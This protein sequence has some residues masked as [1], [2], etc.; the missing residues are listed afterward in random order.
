MTH[1]TRFINKTK[2]KIKKTINKIHKAMR[3]VKNLP[4]IKV[5]NR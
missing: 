4:N 3:T 1:R 2:I 5:V